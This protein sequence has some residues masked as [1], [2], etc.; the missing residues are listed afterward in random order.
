MRSSSFFI[1]VAA[2]IV[3]VS[4]IAAAPVIDTTDNSRTL[5]A[6]NVVKHQSTPTCSSVCGAPNIEACTNV[7]GPGIAVCNTEQFS[8]PNRE[9]YNFIYIAPSAGTCISS[10]DLSR[11]YKP[12]SLI[13][14]ES[15]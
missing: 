5:I 13:V 14:F 8:A 10:G 9:N 7:L 15:H 4:R 3:I 2:L 12:R 11:Q 1:S 6:N